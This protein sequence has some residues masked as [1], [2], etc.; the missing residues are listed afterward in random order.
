MRLLGT[1][2]ILAAALAVA[3]TTPRQTATLSSD[4]HF[5]VDI[6]KIGETEQWFREDFDRSAWSKAVVPKAWDLYEEALWGF[7]GVGWYA[8]TIPPALAAPGRIQT[9]RFGRVMY[10]TKAWLNG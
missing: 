6:E 3:T 1:L 9:L 7:E 8:A 10:H 4:W 2:L 5:T